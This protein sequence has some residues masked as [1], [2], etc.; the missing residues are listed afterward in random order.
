MKHYIILLW[1]HSRAAFSWTAALPPAVLLCTLAL[2]TIIAP[3][4]DRGH[5]LL[6][7]VEGGLPM[8]AALLAAPLLMGDCE[9]RTLPLLAVRRS[10][11]GILVARL[12]V[13]AA[14]LAVCCV[15]AAL[16]AGLFWAIP[17]LW[18]LPVLALP[19]TL[20]AM[21]LALLAAS[22]EC[23]T[24]PGYL[25][26]AAIW[27]GLLFVGRILPLHEPWLTL[28]PFAGSAGYGPEVV[29][30]SKL[31]YTT[32]ALILLLPQWPLVQHPE[33]FMQSS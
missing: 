14:Y 26:P 15:G 18:S 16:A 3:P 17:P 8:V 6:I 28:N 4:R 11:F 10:L 24:V 13:L 1:Y 25:I 12:I 19:P 27:L 31:L 7:A 2:L 33:R 29:A 30:R 20:A 23:S 21:A 32:V 9:R 22:W 5:D